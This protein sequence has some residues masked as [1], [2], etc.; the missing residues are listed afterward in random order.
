M[1]ASDANWA[2]FRVH[3]RCPLRSVF[4]PASLSPGETS[5]PCQGRGPLS[6]AR[7]SFSPQRKP[8]L[9]QACLPRVD[10]RRLPAGAAGVEPRTPPDSP[11]FGVNLTD[12]ASSSA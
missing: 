9:Q 7:P 2:G 12:R 11:M 3:A 1:T 6:P 10:K 8:L 4:R 5:I